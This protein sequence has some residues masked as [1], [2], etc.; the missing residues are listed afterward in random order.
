VIHLTPE[1]LL[2]LAEGARAEH[3][4]PHV[5]AC[6]A[7]A[8]QLSELRGAIEA[9]AEV[10][11]PEPSPLFWNHLSE[12]V[13][14]AVAEDRPVERPGFLAHGWWRFAAAAAVVVAMMLVIAPALRRTPSPGMNNA[15]V[16]PPAELLHTDV[17]LAFDDDPALTLLADLSAGLD[18]EAAAEAGLVPAD[19]AVDGVVLA[20]SEE[21]R[22]ELHR[23]LEEALAASGA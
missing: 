23:L 17:V 10:T 5:Q 14:A 12:R 22:L 15:S 1:Q 13:R 3:E 9:A 4:Y 11:V 16:E 19:G 21:E 7:C 18:W 6:V 20:L 2:D 8:R